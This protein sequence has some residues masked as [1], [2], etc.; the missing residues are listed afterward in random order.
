M[1]ITGTPCS[2]TT[3]AMSGSRCRPQTSLTIAAPAASA[4][5]ATL[6]FM[7]SIETGTPSATA[8]GSTGVRRR[9]SSSIGTG[10]GAAIGAGQFRADVEDVGASGDHPCGLLDRDRGIKKATAVG[11]RVR[12]DVE[13]AHDRWP[14][15][16][17][18]AR[19]RRRVAVL[20]A[21]RGIGWAR[22]RHGVALRPSREECQA[23]LTPGTMDA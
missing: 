16:R 11:E 12:R 3:R 2:A 13:H 1:T 10:N 7:V 4:Q 18:Q 5:A 14:A 19:E 9:I 20:V 8:P 15:Q 21:G 22:E 17:Q 6:A 23:L